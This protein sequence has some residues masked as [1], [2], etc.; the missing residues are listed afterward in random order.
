[1]APGVGLLVDLLRAV[2]R[3]ALPA[4][5]QIAYLRRLGTFPN[6]DELA[7]EVS[8]GV[9]LLSQFVEHGWISPELAEAIR[10]LDS[11][12]TAMSD[13]SMKHLWTAEALVSAPEWERVRTQAQ[14]ILLHTARTEADDPSP[15]QDPASWRVGP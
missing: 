4:Q 13:P 10:E 7:L 15:R 11:V 1:M 6:A 9:G 14:S 8:D 3:L 12:L 5:Q 2:G